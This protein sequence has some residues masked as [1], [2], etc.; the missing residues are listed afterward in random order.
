MYPGVVE[1][2]ALGVFLALSVGPVIFAIIRY[3]IN[4]GYRAGFSFVLGVSF[5]DL[6][7]VVLVNV[8]SGMLDSLRN[9]QTLIGYIGSALLIYMGAVGLFKKIKIRRGSQKVL[10]V[11]SK[12]HAKIWL[13]GFLMNT[14]NPG[15]IIFWLGVGAASTGYVTEHRMV[16]YLTCLLFTLSADV[17]KVFLAHKIREK[18]TLR[19]TIYLNRLSGLFILIGGLVLLVKVAF[20]LSLGH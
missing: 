4:Q 1:G 15:V 16:M 14:L 8:A 11:S 18:L 12:D 7:Y 2:L 13:S 6:L 3:S 19:N 5:S 17:L 20:N 10:T 9:H